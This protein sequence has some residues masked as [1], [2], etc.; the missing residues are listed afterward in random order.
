[1]QIL[2]I[3]KYY[4]TIVMGSFQ[5][6]NNK[7]MNASQIASTRQISFNILRKKQDVSRAYNFFIKNTLTFFCSS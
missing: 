7:T 3:I 4:I 5:M 1:M 6:T 2:I